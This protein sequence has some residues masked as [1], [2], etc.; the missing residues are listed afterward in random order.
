MSNRLRAA[1]ALAPRTDN[2][3]VQRDERLDPVCWPRVSLAAGLKEMGR[4]HLAVAQ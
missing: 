2:A 4:L 3:D 1:C